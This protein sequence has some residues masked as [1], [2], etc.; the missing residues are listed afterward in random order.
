MLTK[1]YSRFRDSI[2]FRRLTAVTRVLLAIGF[3]EPGF[4][5]ISGSPFT[6]LPT[7]NPVGY[8]FD[9]FFQAQAFYF[10]VGFAQVTAAI[11]L[12]FPRTA[13]L[14]AV[15]YFPIILN[16]AVITISIGFK[17]TW[18]VT[19]LMCIGC[20]YLLV[21]DYDRLKALLPIKLSGPAM[22]S[23]RELGIQLVFWT[24]AGMAAYGLGAMVNL[25]NLWSR[26]GLSGFL[27][28]GVAG[29]VFGLLIAGHLKYM[30]SEGVAK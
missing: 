21:W 26:M 2:Q 4:R 11:L 8:F 7:S 19:L 15:M 6:V 14:G 12:L 27:L 20:T 28:A 10:F 30:R 3:L 24:L 5:K 16:I 13:L 29:S 17:G 22:F 9:A 1:L 18:L 25:A 23:R